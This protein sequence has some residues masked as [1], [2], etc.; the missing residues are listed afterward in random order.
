MST[1]TRGS[2]VGWATVTNWKVAV[3]Y[4]NRILS[5]ILILPAAL[6]PG[7]YSASNRNEDQTKKYK[8]YSGSR[9][10]PVRETM[11]DPQHLTGLHGLLQ[12]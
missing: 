12:G 4:C 10:Q 6:G 3:S 7:I 9:A 5:I 8:I 2:A 1:A 11:W